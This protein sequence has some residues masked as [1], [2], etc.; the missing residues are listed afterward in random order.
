MKQ[1]FFIGILSTL[2]LDLLSQNQ[3]TFSIEDAATKEALIGVNVFIPELDKG[4]VSNLEGNCTISNISDGT[5][6]VGISYIGYTSQSLNLTFPTTNRIIIIKLDQ[7]VSNLGE[8]IVTSNRANRS[9][10]NIPSRI[11]VLTDE[12]EEA[13]TMD[14]SK[15]AHLLMHTTGIQVQQTSA[16]SG[17]A[18]VRI[19]GQYGRYTQILKDGFPIYGGFTGGLG[20]LQIPP[21]DLR[22]VEFVKGS[23]STLYG[24]G[25]IAGLINL[26]SK[27]PKA[28]DE[29]S[30]HLNLSHIG[31]TDLNS[32]YSKRSGKWG[33]TV[34]AS[35]NTN[36]LYDVDDDGF[37][38][39]PQVRK[40]NFNPRLFYF[41]DDKTTISFGGT[42]TNENRIGGDVRIVEGFVPNSLHNYFERNKS[43]QVTT[44]FKIDRKL[45][46]SGSIQFKNS[47][48]RFE[49]SIFLNGYAFAGTQF[50]IF[51]E[52]NYALDQDNYHLIVGAN[53][54]TDD[55]REEAIE[56]TQLRD[57]KLFT[58]GAFVQ[59]IWD[60][61]QELA[62]ETG[63]RLDYNQDY[64][65][66]PLPKFALIYKPS[67]KFVARIGGGL[68][69]KLPSVFT[70]NVE[71]LAFEGVQ[72][73]NTTT[74]NAEKSYGLNA[75][76]T[77]RIVNTERFSISLTEYLFYN[78]LNQPLIL[79]SQGVNQYALINS[80][81]YFETRGMESLVKASAENLHLYLGYTF[82]H[83]IQQDNNEEKNLPLTPMHS[84]HGDLMFV[85]EK[86]WRMGIDA[87]Y[88]SQQTLS[89]GR[90][91]RSLFKAGFLAER[92][93]DNFSVYINLENWTDTRQ[94]R[95]ES[96]VQ[97][98]FLNPRFT[99]VWA[100][101]DGFIFNAGFK[102]KM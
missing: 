15:I 91:V 34:F 53:V 22:Q 24:G 43:K 80:E 62:I 71:S 37:T 11:E 75:D 56:T 59:H 83:A 72:P 99:E 55:F 39:V 77:Y 6:E 28:E 50:S 101:L 10:A 82:V 8:V 13:A 35:N 61:H 68:G 4:A 27:E 26:I 41:L 74:N 89:T 64:G 63:F 57:Q 16:T 1:I 84:F 78:R 9:I 94:T 92:T 12:V 25:A 40:F 17:S 93:I 52:L 2:C 5:Y 32:F 66:F 44:Q 102:I 18:S 47:T 58:V 81:G 36:R 96:L 87:E 98:P 33:G 54:Y 20:V 29:F 30:L 3:I 70:E 51:S 48:N 42:F 38:D 46:R 85:Q 65:I 67:L 60:I 31:N 23:S 97:E 7:D 88:E 100:P 73:I 45:S 14:P 19:Q 76:L 21:L 95:Y 79:E 69:Y 49:R 90:E 86:K